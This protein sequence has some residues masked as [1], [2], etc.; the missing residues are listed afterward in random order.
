ML[1]LSARRQ[2]F[3]ILHHRVESLFVLSVR[4][5]VT[6][7][8]FH[9]YKQDLHPELFD[10]T[11]LRVIE[12]EHYELTLR[13]TTDGHSVLFRSG[14][15]Q[16]V[17]IGAAANHPLPQSGVLLSRSLNRVAHRCTYHHQSVNYAADVQLELVD[18]KTFV[19]INQHLDERIETEGL[20]H[21]FGTNGRISFGAMSYINVQAF[22]EHVKVRTFH[23]FPET[24]AVLKADTLFSLKAS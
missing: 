13:I 19:T 6:G 16:L 22:R 14:D 7:L 4:P 11:A 2:P 12:R 17:E 5:K 23:T 8:Q 20:V 9:L 24:C 1:S 18:P 21:R 3:L 15:T 10:V